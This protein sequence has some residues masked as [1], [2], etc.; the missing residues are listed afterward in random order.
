[1]P[2]PN[3]AETLREARALHTH[4]AHEHA[5]AAADAARNGAMARFKEVVV[6][7][8]L[9][10]VN[11]FPGTHPSVIWGDEI[12]DLTDEFIGF[13]DDRDFPE[14]KIFIDGTWYPPVHTF[15]W[16]KDKVTP[17]YWEPNREM[18]GYALGVFSSKYDVEPWSRED[19]PRYVHEHDMHK[20]H[21]SHPP[22]TFLSDGD[23]PQ[24]WMM[25]LGEDGLLRGHT[26]AKVEEGLHSRKTVP[27]AL[28]RDV[29]PLY[30]VGGG[31]LDT[32]PAGLLLRSNTAI[33]R[34]TNDPLY[35]QYIMGNNIVKPQEV[36]REIL[37]KAN[38]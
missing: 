21:G 14:S 25:F 35:G 27:R 8:R 32:A 1:M 11:N 9:D 6:R 17:G 38:I 16:G 3:F 12:G 28:I 34:D 29:P 19:Y 24:V 23:R 13:M 31:Q 5:V 7:E 22:R 18:A 15:R 37:R 4:D 36:L 33:T 30:A 2:T 26:L 10:R 20:K